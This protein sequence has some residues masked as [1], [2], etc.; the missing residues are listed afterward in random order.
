MFFYFFPRWMA[1]DSPKGE[2]R[3]GSKEQEN[4]IIAGGKT[5]E[6]K[7]EEKS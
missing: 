7:L 6:K 3:L 1:S 4:E 2:S 5:K